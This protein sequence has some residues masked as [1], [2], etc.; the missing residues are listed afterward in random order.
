[1][2]LPPKRNRI[3]ETGRIESVARLQ[4]QTVMAESI[5]ALPRIK[6]IFTSSSMVCPSRREISSANVFQC[7]GRRSGSGA[8][9]PVFSNDFRGVIQS[10]TEMNHFDCLLAIGA[11]RVLC[12][13]VSQN[14][15]TKLRA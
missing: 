10:R 5:N 2:G 7:P 15:V 14:E 4:S 12:W 8:V 9:R 3:A 11:V 13:P 1:M 6:N